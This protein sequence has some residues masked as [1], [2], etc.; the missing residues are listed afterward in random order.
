MTLTSITPFEIG[1]IIWF[2]LGL[3]GTISVALDIYFIHPQN[4]INTNEDFRKFGISVTSTNIFTLALTAIFGP[5]G[6]YLGIRKIV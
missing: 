6:L 1:L 4:Y 5:I 2:A 3:L